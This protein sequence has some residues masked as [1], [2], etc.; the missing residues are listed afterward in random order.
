VLEG[1]EVVHRG[2]RGSVCR[3]RDQVEGVDDIGALDQP[4]DRGKPA[5]GPGAM[6]DAKRYGYAPHPLR[7]GHDG[8]PEGVGLDAH[9]E[10]LKGR[11]QFTG[12]P[13][14]ACAAGDERADIDGDA[15]RAR[16]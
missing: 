15:E 4:V 9:A 3:R 13:G 2:H 10:G 14:H 12:I 16:D 1:V 7:R 5:D 8:A 6:Q 11:C